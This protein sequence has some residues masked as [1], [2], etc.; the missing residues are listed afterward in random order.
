MVLYDREPLALTCALVSAHLNFSPIRSNLP[1][2]LPELSDFVSAS[3]APIKIPE[4]IPCNFD[5]DKFHD[6]NLEYLE[7]PGTNNKIP[8]VEAQIFDWAS[9]ETSIPGYDVVC[10]LFYICACF[11]NS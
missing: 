3:Q 1:Q 4:V 7:T 5:E 10:F 11:D 2:F 6:S 9:K 8:T